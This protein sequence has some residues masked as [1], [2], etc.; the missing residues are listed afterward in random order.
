MLQVFGVY[1]G[2]VPVH[3]K[4]VCLSARFVLFCAISEMCGKAFQ[5]KFLVCAVVEHNWIFVSE[6]NIISEIFSIFT[7]FSMSNLHVMIQSILFSGASI[8]RQS[9]PEMNK[10]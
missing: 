5:T 4:I 1:S 7:R 2:K 10:H 8:D 3:C 6:P 9:V